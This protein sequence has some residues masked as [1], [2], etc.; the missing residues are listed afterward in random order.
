MLEKVFAGLDRV[1]AILGHAPGLKFGGLGVGVCDGSRSR[2]TKQ[3]F[4]Y[5]SRISVPERA[6]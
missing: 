4:C 5:D 3:F 2:Q 1:C 6:K